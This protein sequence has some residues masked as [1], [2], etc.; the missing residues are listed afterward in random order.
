M[1]KNVNE[2][3][4]SFIK[5]KEN[6]YMQTLTKTLLE[7]NKIH[8]FCKSAEK[9][10]NDNY[11]ELK[12][13]T[14]DKNLVKTPFERMIS[15]HLIEHFIKKEINIKP[16]LNPI[17]SDMMFE[18]DDCFLNIDCKTDNIVTNKGDT[19][20]I[21]IMP[22]QITFEAKPLFKR[23]IGE[24]IFSGIHYTGQQKPIINNKPNLTFMF[25]LVYADNE[26]L[27]D[28]QKKQSSKYEIGKYQNLELALT[29]IPNGLTLSEEDKGDIVQNIK[30]Y[31]YVTANKNFS[32]KYKP[33]EKISNNWI[34]FKNNSKDIYLDTELKH[35]WYEDELVVRGLQKKK[36]CV[37]LEGMSARLNKS[38]VSE[39][40]THKIS[41][42]SSS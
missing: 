39:Y 13:K 34:L 23:N 11:K 35:P 36:Y 25:K 26:G 18:L 31:H 1:T 38:K 3:S 4:S 22:N 19:K 32:P 6:E 21:S 41:S 42:G 28:A 16:H 14:T 9:E 33:L 12:E 2:I 29:Y 24:H 15:F 17:T 37:I 5:D 8:D 7:N 40:K 10:I 30:T 27:T 20:D